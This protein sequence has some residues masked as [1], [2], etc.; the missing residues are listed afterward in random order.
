MGKAVIVSFEDSVIKVVYT[1]AKGGNV[2]VT[3]TLILN[4]EQFD[5]FLLQE[6]TSQFIVTHSFKDFF[7]EIF[8]IPPVK[9]KYVKSLIEA[10]IKRK[11]LFP[12]FSFIHTDLGEKV[13]DGKKM[14]EVF[15]FAVRNDEINGIVNRFVSRDKLVKAFYP[16]IFVIASMIDSKDKPVLCVIE[17]G[18]NKTLFL[19]NKGNVC[20]VRTVQSLEHGLGDLDIQNINMTTNYCWQS[21]KMGPSIIMLTEHLC[22]N[23][24][25]TMS[26]AAPIACLTQR[27]VSAKSEIAHDYTAAVSVLLVPASGKINLLTK[28]FK[29]FFQ[30]RQFLIYS[31]FLFLIL[32]FIGAGYAAYSTTKIAEMKM[33]LTSARKTLPGIEG[34]ITA[35]DG[36]SEDLN[37][38]APYLALINSSTST[39]DL[40]GFLFLLS[41]LNIDSVKFVS[42]S[43]TPGEHVL[44]SELKGSVKLDSYGDAQR[45]YQLLVDRIGKLKGIIVTDHS[46]DIIKKEF[47]IK[48]DFNDL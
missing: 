39:P 18:L 46:F 47:Q 3:D 10:E 21:L 27:Y 25:A 30:V 11:A 4:D 24:N 34:I 7:Q 20:F 42:I 44:H 2:A 36:K 35:Y 15:V 32:S 14:R 16:D 31:S 12:S 40:Q 29:R 19:V 22:R 23:Y 17:A 37:R 38:Y 41:E 1:S 13:V 8:F 5:N 33:R 9:D 45:D 28:E 43:V 26:A 6:K 48:A